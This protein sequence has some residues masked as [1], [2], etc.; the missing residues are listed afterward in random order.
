M[1]WAIKHDIYEP[2]GVGTDYPVVR[3]IFYGRTK[4]EAEGYF[5]AHMGTD[6]F[7][8]D[9]ENTGRFGEIVCKTESTVTTVEKVPPLGLSQDSALGHPLAEADKGLSTGAKAA[10]GVGAGVVAIGLLAAVCTWRRRA[11]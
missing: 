11:R 4:K 2:E 3:H 1:L 9:C 5:S 7:L 6:T 8:R 10:I